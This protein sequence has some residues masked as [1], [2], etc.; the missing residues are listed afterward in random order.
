MAIGPQAEIQTLTLGGKRFVL[1]PERE[2]RRLT[3]GPPEPNL[4]PPDAAGNYPAVETMRVMLAQKL[5]RARRA[6]GLTQAQLAKLAGVRTQ[7]VNRLEAG[8]SSPNV[9]TVDKIHRALEKAGKK[10]APR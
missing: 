9:A 6:A 7:T 2:Y 4:P 5:I 1:M 3:G 8:K 10:Q